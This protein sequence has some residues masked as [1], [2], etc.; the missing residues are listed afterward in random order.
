M[1]YIDQF[2]QK[3]ELNKLNRTLPNIDES[4]IALLHAGVD[5]KR[6]DWPW[7]VRD[8]I[9]IPR[10][11]DEIVIGL[12]GDVELGDLKHIER[13]IDTLRVVAPTLKISYST[14]SDLVTLPIHFSKCTT[15]FS[16]LFNYCDAQGAW[17]YYYDVDTP[18]HGWIW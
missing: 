3:R 17:G 16:D 18:L 7:M 4:T 11:E 5:S 14:N 6:E 15:E 2:F 13:L 8:Y 1:K 10:I 9:M 12:F